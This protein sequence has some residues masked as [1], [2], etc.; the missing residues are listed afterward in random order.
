M[1]HMDH[2][3]V[4]ATLREMWDTRPARRRDDRQVAGVASAIARRYD[5]DPTLVR[6]GFV[7][8]AISGGIGA[9]LYIA[10]WAVLPEEDG[11]PDA[12][13][14]PRRGIAVIGLV[15]AV[16]VM[17]GW[18]GDGPGPGPIVGGLVALGLL[19]L[20]H[21][22]RS[23]QPVE[24]PTAT[25]A[26]IDGQPDAPTTTTGTGPSLVKEATASAAP[27]WPEAPQ[28]PPSW[29]PLGAAPFAWDLPDPSPTPTPA[30]PV[31]R[32]PVTSVTLGVALL[33]A[34]ATAII[35]LLAGSLTA[36]NVPILLGVLLAVVGL[37]LVVGSF[38]RSGRGLIPI[39]LVL[40]AMTWVALTAPLDRWTAGG[41]GDVE[42]TPR[43]AAEVLPLYER[44]AGNLDLDLSRLNLT[45]AP[46]SNADPIRTRIELGLGDVDVTVPE[47]A[48]VTL[49]ASVG[50]G[51]LS[52]GERDQS[53]GGVEMRETDLGEDGVAS[54]R[55]IILDIDAG[56]GNVEVHRG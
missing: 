15:I 14:R 6:I 10:L 40:C 19:Y 30:P 17:F 33:A 52:F 26:P 28:T 4:Q 35:L 47:N 29:D 25:A 11:G 27:V 38:A 21:R 45:P 22:S 41:V 32:L 55:P 9:A 53:G 16:L 31:K 13:P 18:F 3:D 49:N 37:G 54:G 39:A 8:A 43:T 56:A 42:Y 48:D 50:M 24:G 1:R 46:G 5:I 7:V 12:R 23:G 34:G 2:S 51:D 20:L 44:S 36:A